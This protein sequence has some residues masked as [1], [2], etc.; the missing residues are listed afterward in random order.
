MFKFT[1]FKK[2]F[3]LSFLS[4]FFIYSFSSCS[5]NAPELNNATLSIIFD[6]DSYE[7][8]P[9]ARLCVFVEASS[10]P[11][12]FETI[13]VSSDKNEL[14][15]Q[16]DDLILAENGQIKYCGLTNLVMPEKEIIPAGEYTITFRQ[17]DAE[18]K[19]VKTKLRYEPL[20]Y[21]TIG[22]DVP[23]LI[24]HLFFTKMITIY[25]EEKNIIFY[26]QRTRELSDSRGIWNTFPTAAEFQES[27]INLNNT[28][29]CN[30]PMEK[31]TPGN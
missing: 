30:M 3:F 22:S 20:L 8:L 18:E 26:G 16:S 11:T 27:W 25:D 13:H 15:W 17:S 28:V 12:R 2:T 31:V 29:I 14:E 24:K 6:Y 4:L 5:N 1:S 19:Q 9:K 10:N 21:E 7:E 23:D